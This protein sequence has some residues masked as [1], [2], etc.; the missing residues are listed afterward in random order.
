VGRVLK[1]V[2]TVAWHPSANGGMGRAAVWMDSVVLVVRMETWKEVFGFR[3]TTVLC[4]RE[5]S[6][7]ARGSDACLET[8][9][10]LGAR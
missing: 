9:A 4:S 10:F 5:Q 3:S 6:D 2:L 1:G 8:C 7:Y